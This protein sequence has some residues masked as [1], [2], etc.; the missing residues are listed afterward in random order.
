M[1]NPER[2]R[3]RITVGRGPYI[4]E[5]PVA[6]CDSDDAPIATP[7]DGPVA[8]CRCG[9]SGNKPFC[10]GSHVAVGFDGTVNPTNRAPS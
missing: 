5:G 9:A 6:I 2:D 4:L 8:L 7:A 3:T 1:S 10:D